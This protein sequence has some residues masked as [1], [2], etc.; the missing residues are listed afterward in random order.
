MNPSDRI[1][2]NIRKRRI[3]IEKRFLDVLALNRFGEKYERE[4]IKKSTNDV[5]RDLLVGV[6]DI[7]PLDA[8]WA[9]VLDA[10]PQKKQ[11]ELKY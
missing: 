8:Y 7:H 9:I 11:T 3:K 2:I 6:E 10:L 4:E 5:L 1:Q